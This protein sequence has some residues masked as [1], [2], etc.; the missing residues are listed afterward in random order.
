M[1]EK[2]EHGNPLRSSCP[3]CQRDDEI[4]ELKM[5]L[6]FHELN[7]DTIRKQQQEIVRLHNE[8]RRL[9][10]GESRV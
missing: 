6:G 7:Q 3:I 4:T 5:R 9:H 1:A 2:C 8:I 10:K